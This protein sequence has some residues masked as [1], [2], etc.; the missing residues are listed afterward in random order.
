LKRARFSSR[1]F[2]YFARGSLC[3]PPGRQSR[4]RRSRGVLR[5]S[6]AASRDGKILPRSI[7]TMAASG[8][9]ACSCFSVGSRS[10]LSRPRN[11]VG[12]PPAMIVQ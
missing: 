11:A 2:S 3:S 4:G 5:S 1:V 7:H 9:F 12:C 8:S 10:S 6:S